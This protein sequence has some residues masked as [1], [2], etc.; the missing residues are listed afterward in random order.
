[1]GPGDTAHEQ[2]LDAHYMLPCYRMEGL[3][4]GRPPFSILPNTNLP[5][6]LPL[7]KNQPPQNFTFKD[8]HLL[9]PPPVMG[10]SMLLTVV[11]CVLN[12]LQFLISNL[13]LLTHLMNLIIL[14]WED[15]AEELL[16]AVQTFKCSL[17][18][19]ACLE[20][21]SKSNL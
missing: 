7:V 16:M 3:Q 19:G 9:K 21:K 5:L 13:M 11:D 15:L 17:K 2:V 18:A 1:M 10:A 20:A 12:I 8:Q 6:N 14:Q 4:S